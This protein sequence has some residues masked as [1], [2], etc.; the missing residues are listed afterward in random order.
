MDAEA[1]HRER[2]RGEALQ[3]RVGVDPRDQRLGHT[4]L[5]P[6]ASRD[7]VRAETAEDEPEFDGAKAPSQFE[8]VVHQ[9]DVAVTVRLQIFR[10]K[11]EGLTEQ[12]RMPGKERGAVD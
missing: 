1:D 4:H 12:I 3:L 7:A 2:R 11:R 5:V 10:Q 9:V 8:G 6:D